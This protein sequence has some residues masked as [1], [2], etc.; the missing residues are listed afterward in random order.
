MQL[1]TT[2]KY[3]LSCVPTGVDLNEALKHVLLP[4]ILALEQG[5]FRT[6]FAATGREESFCGTIFSVLGDHMGQIVLQG[7]KGPQ[8]N[9]PSRYYLTP[10]ASMDEITDVKVKREEGRTLTFAIRSY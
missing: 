1:Q 9:F 4:Y 10:L 7:I 6:F 3:L 8:C 5:D 2:R